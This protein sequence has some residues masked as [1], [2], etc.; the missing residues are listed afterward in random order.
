MG[1]A[2]GKRAN[3]WTVTEAYHI[4][5]PVVFKGRL[6]MEARIAIFETTAGNAR[7]F[8]MPGSLVDGARWAHIRIFSVSGDR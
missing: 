5:P 2:V 6:D 8:E 7:D 1:T 4:R 3:A